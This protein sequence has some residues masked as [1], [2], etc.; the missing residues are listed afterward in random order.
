MRP[1]FSTLEKRIYETFPRKDP[2][3]YFLILAGWELK[4]LL[5]R[6]YNP[7]EKT[8][9]LYEIL[10]EKLKEKSILIINFNWDIYFEEACNKVGR[11][12]RLNTDGDKE[13]VEQASQKAITLCKPHGGWNIQHVDN[14]ILPFPT[15]S[16]F[17]EDRSFDRF[18]AGEVRPA[19]IPYFSS[20][21]EISEE[22]RSRFP[23]VGEYFKKQHEVMK[24]MFREAEHIVSIGYSFSE[25]ADGIQLFQ[26][27]QTMV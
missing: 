26:K 4:H 23:G 24:K 25:A 12:L 10:L 11:G 14:V 8:N 27:K 18:E 9:Q 17:I 16:D 6:T 21:D 20:P 7:Q 5:Y 1:L 19:M 15:L 13:S 2:I 22:H 3:E